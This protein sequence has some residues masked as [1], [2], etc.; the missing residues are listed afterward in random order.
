[1]SAGIRAGES[2]GLARKCFMLLESEDFKGKGKE[3]SDC[4]ESATIPQRPT[5][6]A[7]NK[8]LR[9]EPTEEISL[10]LATL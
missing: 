8:S 6:V 10:T 3:S 4:L 5:A 1:M 7:Y 2:F 9:K